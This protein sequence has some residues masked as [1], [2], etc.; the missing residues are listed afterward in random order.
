[1]QQLARHGR[2]RQRMGGGLGYGYHGNPMD[3]RMRGN[4]FRN[5]MRIPVNMN[6]LRQGGM[7]PMGGIGGGGLG[8]MDP[9]RAMGGGLRGMG[10]MDPLRGLGG[11]NDAPFADVRLG[12]R[13][14][15]PISYDNYDNFVRPGFTQ[16]DLLAMQ[17]RPYGHLYY[18]SVPDP[19][20]GCDDCRRSGRR[21][22]LDRYHPRSRDSIFNPSDRPCAAKAEAKAK[23][24]KYD[25][26]TKDITVRG[27]SYSV[28][29]SFLAESSKFEADFIKFVDK[30]T[31][32][33]VP[34]TVVQMLI[35]FINEEECSGSTLLEWVQLNIL[36]SSLGAKSAIEYS[37]NELKKGTSDSY[38]VRAREL[39]N[40]CVAVLMSSRVD[41]GLE[42]WLKKFLQ[43]DQRAEQL[44]N[45]HDFQD[46][47]EDHPELYTKVIELL[48]KKKKADD[49][50]LPIL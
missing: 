40:I 1:M 15:H 9:L 22:D 8:G 48:D 37:L 43:H 5:N 36:A 16:A 24:E 2:D 45:T 4:M 12:R 21:C 11:Y 10:G 28:R 29:K 38:S 44:V 33:N 7:G 17:Q 35:D 34:S 3:D 20:S 19:G 27:V 13:R 31:E 50:A 14:S 23:K 39:T 46:I 32:D 30:K 26:K 25:F 42:G 41:S 49:G 18:N 6:P 47:L